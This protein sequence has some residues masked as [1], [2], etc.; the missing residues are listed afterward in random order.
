MIPWLRSEVCKEMCISKSI[1]YECIS[2]EGLNNF[3]AKW[4]ASD[5]TLIA[6]VGATKG[7]TAF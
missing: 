6:L 2:E 7:I 4:F 3:N 5:T 1:D